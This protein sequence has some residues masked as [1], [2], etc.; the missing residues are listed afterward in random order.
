[1]HPYAG[2]ALSANFRI[3]IPLALWIFNNNNNILAIWWEHTRN[4]GFS[5]VRSYLYGRN[6][7]FELEN[8]T[9]LFYGRFFQVGTIYIFNL[10]GKCS[11]FRTTPEWGRWSPLIVIH[12]FL[13]FYRQFASLRRCHYSATSSKNLLTSIEHLPSPLWHCSSNTCISP[14]CMLRPPLHLSLF[15]AISWSYFSPLLSSLLSLR[16][17]PEVVVVGETGRGGGSLGDGGGGMEGRS[18]PRWPFS[19]RFP[20]LSIFLFFFKPLASLALGSMDDCEE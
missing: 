2:R 18:P 11:E 16:Q 5:F 20:S 1:M 9:L 14:V 4:S 3:K 7:N 6:C 15:T 12:L 19:R 17:E 10:F 8:F 13:H